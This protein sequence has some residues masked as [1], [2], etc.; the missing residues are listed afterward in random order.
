MWFETN[1]TKLK[2]VSTHSIFIYHLRLV[3][4]VT[5]IRKNG[6]FR[7]KNGNSSDWGRVLR[8]LCKFV[9]NLNVLA[10]HISVGN[11][12]HIYGVGVRFSNVSNWMKGWAYSKIGHLSALVK[13]DLNNKIW[14]ER[15]Y[16]IH[17]RYLIILFIYFS[18][19][20][21]V[22]FQFHFHNIGVLVENVVFFKN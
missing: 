22:Q 12:W 4:L 19:N 10:H 17:P 15:K 9:L 6:I 2:T 21:D 16:K 20:S 13:S 14:L 7:P 3:K 18:L 5:S 1:Y 11:C 8:H